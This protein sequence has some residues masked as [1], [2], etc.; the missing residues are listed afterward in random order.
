MGDG[1]GCGKEQA[2]R[3]AAGQRGL[4][5]RDLARV[6]GL[7]AH[8]VMGQDLAL[9]RAARKGGLRAVEL[10]IAAPDDE[11]AGARGLREVEMRVV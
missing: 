8:P 11:A 10:E 6:E 4:R 3:E 9:E 7:G 1:A 5:G 2:P